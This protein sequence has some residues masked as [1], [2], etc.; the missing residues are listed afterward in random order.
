LL[1]GVLADVHFSQDPERV[2]LLF[3]HL[4][5]NVDN[6]KILSVYRLAIHMLLKRPDTGK[7][8][9]NL[10]H[11]PALQGK[12]RELLRTALID[13]RPDKR[14]ILPSHHNLVYTPLGATQPCLYPMN[15]RWLSPQLTCSDMDIECSIAQYRREDDPFEFAQAAELGDTLYGLFDNDPEV[16]EILFQHAILSAAPSRIMKRFFVR[17]L[18]L[19][20]EHLDL[21]AEVRCMSLNLDLLQDA[22]EAPYV[23]VR[24]KENCR[25]R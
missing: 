24:T 19:T 15:L 5:R 4:Q 12:G 20:G 17:G 25:P 11:E 21:L 9:K 10:L 2:R 16:L 7:I 3:N 18:H 23:E 22:Y 8:I 13:R 6:A 14:V 1:G